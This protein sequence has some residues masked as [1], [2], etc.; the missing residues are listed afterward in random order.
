MEVF[1]VRH[2]RNR[3]VQSILGNVSIDFLVGGGK[4]H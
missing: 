3:S 1:M 2:L 4:G